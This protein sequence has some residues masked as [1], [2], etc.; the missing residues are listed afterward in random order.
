MV[1]RGDLGSAVEAPRGVHMSAYGAGFV[2]GTPITV[3][4]GTQSTKS[5]GPTD[6]PSRGPIWQRS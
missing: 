1:R 2:N 3:V 4:F 6:K 5:N